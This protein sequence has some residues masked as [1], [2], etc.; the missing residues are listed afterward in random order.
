VATLLASNLTED[1]MVRQLFLAALGR[2][3]T[4][5]ETA[6]LQANRASRTSREDWL[7]DVQWALLNKLDFIFNY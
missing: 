4:A 5:D 3:P 1:E 7:T 6:A 2:N